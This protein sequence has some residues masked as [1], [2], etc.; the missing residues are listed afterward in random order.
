MVS[1]T[2]EKAKYVGYALQLIL[3]LV[4]VI[5]LAC[6]SWALLGVCLG[7]TLVLLV[8]VCLQLMGKN[9]WKNVQLGKRRDTMAHLQGYPQTWAQPLPQ[10]VQ[11]LPMAPPQ[12][13]PPMYRTPPAQA[14]LT[15]DERTALQI[16]SMTDRGGSMQAPVLPMWNQRIVAV[17]QGQDLHGHTDAYHMPVANQ[18]QTLPVHLDVEHP[19]NPMNSLS[20][21]YNN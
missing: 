16:M 10:P 6:K 2:P 13:T 1:I 7:A 14:P 12:Y 4:L 21:L 3:V 8:L 18:A 11:Y 17:S 9:Q 19:D 5:S 20:Y 15:R